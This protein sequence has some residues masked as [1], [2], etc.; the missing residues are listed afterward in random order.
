MTE[1]A[2]TQIIRFK[3]SGEIE[4]T[5][6]GIQ[7]FQALP[8]PIGIVSILGPPSTGKSTF[9]KKLSGSSRSQE[10]SRTQGIWA[11]TDIIKVIKRDKDG[12]EH[13]ADIL[14]IDCEPIISRL[15]QNKTRGLEILTL[16]CLISSHIVYYDNRAIH[17]QN[18][19]DL[20]IF[21]ELPNMIEIHKHMD[22]FKAL[23]EYMP[24][25]TW[26]IHGP[27]IKAPEES[28]SSYLEKILSL[29]SNSDPSKI[30]TAIKS[31][32]K[33]RNCFNVLSNNKIQYHRLVEYIQQTTPNKSILGLNITGSILC[34]MIQNYF[35][36]LQ[37]KKLVIIQSAFNKA[38]ATEA[39]KNIEKLYVGYLE[40]M[41]NIEDKLPCNDE[42]LWVDHSENTKKMIEKYNGIMS[43]YSGCEEVDIEKNTILHRTTNFY[44]E[45]KEANMRKS[46]ELCRELFRK[47]F[48]PVKKTEFFI[49]DLSENEAKMLNGLKNY[50]E[51][52][53]GPGCL[54]VALEEFSQM[55]PFFCRHI[56]EV[57]IQH[58]NTIEDLQQ[59]VE[60]L[61]KTRDKARQNEKKI[62]EILDETIKNYESQISNKDKIISE[63]QNSFNTKQSAAESK[64]KTLTRELKALHQELD[65]IQKEKQLLISMEKEA[66]SCK[67]DEYEDIISKLKDQIQILQ[68]KH[69]DFKAYHEKSL[70]EK[71]DEIFEL[72][73]KEKYSE[74]VTESLQDFSILSS[75]R[76]DIN[77]MFILLE[78]EQANNNKYAGQMDKVSA[79]QN[80]FNKFRLKEIENKNRLTEEYEEK[81]S[82]LKDEI[83][84]LTYQLNTL[85]T[86]KTK[87]KS[88]KKVIKQQQNDEILTKTCDLEK[89]NLRLKEKN[90]ILQEFLDKRDEQIKGLYDV[91]ETWKIKAQEI[92]YDLED[93][94]N[95]LK[96]VK[97]D[98]IEMRDDNDI[99][100]GLMGYSLEISQ[101]KRNIQAISLK[102]IAN[103]QNRMRVVKIFKKFG[104]PFD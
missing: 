69:T 88:V 39:R 101:K 81:I 17:T 29:Q 4:L 93:K 77:E 42:E 6:E 71:D 5:T 8:K 52:A 55:I 76:R 58:E 2:Y 9:A 12:T 10:I 41:G 32:F 13:K 75:L 74:S 86:K 95:E 1:S 97:V 24:V 99:L 80:E 82:L 57:K 48:E 103:L 51:K 59:E 65:H 91:I 47:A 90:I 44:E 67:I 62:K 11:F 53:L 45:L 35:L 22:S 25:L 72:K 73:Q 98:V 79:I 23:H 21:A 38:V 36:R 27:D 40:S 19:Q 94:Q 26:V 37:N 56:R 28:A 102:Q 70:S 50:S 43:E 16:A 15:D 64:V 33:S 85:K 31:F 60:S 61:K 83:D 100:I 34:S 78:T 104:I 96:K 20:G 63:M 92:Q 49:E 46:Q 66:F 3:N 7:L 84:D 18:M 30:K 14:I 68:S 54:K 87:E 89:D